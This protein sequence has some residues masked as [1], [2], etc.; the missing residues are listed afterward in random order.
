MAPRFRG[1]K[2]LKY[3]DIEDKKHAAA[4][5]AISIVFYNN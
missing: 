3:L 4:D 1:I 2:L 5:P